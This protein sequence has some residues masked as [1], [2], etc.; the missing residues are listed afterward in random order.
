MG[1]KGEIIIYETGDREAQLEVKLDQE[2][3]LAYSSS[4]SEVV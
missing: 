3:D 4:N 2:N 1:N